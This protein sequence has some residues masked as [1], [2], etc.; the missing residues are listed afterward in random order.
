MLKGIYYSG[1]SHLYIDKGQRAAETVM[2]TLLCTHMQLD[3][4]TLIRVNCLVVCL[5]MAY[6]CLK[7]LK[8]GLA[9]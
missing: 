9:L 2:R 5:S 7:F 6:L 3:C 4:E 8:Y 1:G